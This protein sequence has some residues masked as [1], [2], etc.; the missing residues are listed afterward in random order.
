MSHIVFEKYKYL[1]VVYNSGNPVF[2][3]YRPIPYLQGNVHIAAFAFDVAGIEG[4]GVTA[5]EDMAL[6]A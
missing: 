5:L 6:A 4:F 2:L 1:P 3:P